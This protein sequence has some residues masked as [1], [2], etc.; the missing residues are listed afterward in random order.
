[1]SDLEQSRTPPPVSD[2]FKQIIGSDPIELLAIDER[3]SDPDYLHQVTA[4][5]WKLA[6]YYYSRTNPMIDD[7]I[8]GPGYRHTS[9]EFEIPSIRLVEWGLVSA[10]TAKKIIEADKKSREA[11]QNVDINVPRNRISIS[12][13]NKVGPT[14]ERTLSI[15]ET[16]IREDVIPDAP[17]AKFASRVEEVTTLSGENPQKLQLATQRRITGRSVIIG[18][19]ILKLADEEIKKIP[20]E[21]K[22]SVRSLNTTLAFLVSGVETVLPKIR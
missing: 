17:D 2:R 20:V 1:M 22:L 10:I 3:L 6:E 14:N 18:Q 4:F 21:T 19:N 15:T 8:R 16:Y 12:I 9:V 5:I 7:E 11:G 13:Q